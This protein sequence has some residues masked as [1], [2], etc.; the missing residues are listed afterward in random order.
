MTHPTVLTNMRGIHAKPIADQV[1]GYVLC[2][3]RNL[4]TY[5]W[6]QCEARWEPLGGEAAR[7]GYISGPG[8]VTALD[9]GS[10]DLGGAVLGI[11]GFGSIGQEV[12][13]RA[14]A[15]SM[16]VVAVDP[17]PPGAQQALVERVFAVSE[18]DKMLGTSDFVVICAPHT[19][20]TLHLFDRERLARMK[21]SSFLINVGRGVLVDQGALTSALE[22]G[23]LAGAALDV[24][25][26]EPLPADNPL[27]GLRNV[28]LTPHTAGYAPSVA[29]EFQAVLSE[30]IQRFTF[31][32]TLMNVVD[33]REWY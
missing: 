16:H 8:T 27:W 19:P 2:F 15:F 24:F 10:I 29:A 30:N 12:A 17:R 21:R 23:A 9:R 14:S 33:K 25:E 1:M 7:P 6:Q 4:H 32:Q 3:A 22:A 11:V 20:Q 13:K 18:L 31:G 26:E 5:L 28:I